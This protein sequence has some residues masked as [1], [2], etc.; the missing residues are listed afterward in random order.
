MSTL[1]ATI[2]ALAAE[3]AANVIAAMKSASLEE[4]MIETDMPHATSARA[5]GVRGGRGSGV[6]VAV[7][8]RSAQKRGRLP[9]RSPEAIARVRDQIVQLLA[10]HPKGLR[11]EQIQTKLGISRKEI[12]RPLNEALSSRLITKK[13]AKRSTTYFKR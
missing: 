8:A 6:A 13:G 4:I 9:R 12:P 1:K 5:S 10:K 7:G 2:E 11:S 3:F